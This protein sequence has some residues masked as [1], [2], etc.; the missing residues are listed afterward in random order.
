MHV[1][2]KPVGISGFTGFCRPPGIAEL[3]VAGTLASFPDRPVGL[4]P[5][6]AFLFICQHICYHKDMTTR[7]VLDT[8]VFIAAVLGPRG[9]SREVLRRCLRQ[10]YQPL[11]G[12]TLFLEYES[13]LAR[14]ALFTH[15][16][17]S[18]E[19]REIVFNA[20]LSV[21]QWQAVYYAWR[22]NLPDEADNHLVELAVAGRAAAIVTKNVRDFVHAELHF[23]GLR[24]M[25]PETFLEEGW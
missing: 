12:T 8:N 5:Q 1:Y 19:E 7:I 9:A 2:E 3:L 24:I 11:M 17:L 18:P 4:F 25:P 23:P 13:V 15:C 10:R 21:C 6:E 14:D 22:P 16:R 20:L